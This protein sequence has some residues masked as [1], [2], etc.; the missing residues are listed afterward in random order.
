MLPC[1]ATLCF[2]HVQARAGRAAV[3]SWTRL[4][5]VALMMASF[6]V[7]K[8]ATVIAGHEIAA[9]GLDE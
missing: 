6:C 9:S 3:G 2:V 5:L 4:Q 1:L 7:L 8:A